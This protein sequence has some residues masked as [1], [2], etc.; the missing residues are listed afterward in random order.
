MRQSD[1]YVGGELNVPNV[2][3]QLI[4]VKRHADLTV[5]IHSLLLRAATTVL[6]LMIAL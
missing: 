1:V 6:E 2:L 5:L 4:P 3:M